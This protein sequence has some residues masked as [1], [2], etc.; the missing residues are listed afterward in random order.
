[1]PLPEICARSRVTTSISTVILVRRAGSWNAVGDLRSIESVCGE[2]DAAT[3]DLRASCVTT[4]EGC[5]DCD[6][7]GATASARRNNS[8]FRICSF[9]DRDCL[10]FNKASH[11]FGRQKSCSSISG[12]AYRRGAC[13][14]NSGYDGGFSICTRVNM[15]CLARAE[16]FRTGDLDVR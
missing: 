16:A 9:V 3:R 2:G 5:D 12:S 8:R 15:D 4:S 13:C 6:G 7:G 1:M 10:A 11:A 14:S